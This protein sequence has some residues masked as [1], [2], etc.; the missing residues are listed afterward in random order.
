MRMQMKNSCLGLVAAVLASAANCAYAA[1]GDWLARV[2]LI[3]INP[4]VSSSLAGLD[5]S[6]ETAPEVDLSYFLTDSVA[7]ELI[8]TDRK[9]NVSLGGANLGI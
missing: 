3:N 9:F 8:A 4:S 1:Q 6:T 5:V 2:R 7:L